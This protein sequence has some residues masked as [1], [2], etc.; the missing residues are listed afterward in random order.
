VFLR[1]Y[2]DFHVK[3]EDVGLQVFIKSR[4]VVFSSHLLISSR[5]GLSSVFG[6]QREKIWEL[7]DFKIYEVRYIYREST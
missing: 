3:E 6:G 2:L 5:A 4:L 7:L 1:E